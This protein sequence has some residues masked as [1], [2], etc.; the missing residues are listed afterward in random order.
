[1]ECAVGKISSLS[2]PKSNRVNW[3]TKFGT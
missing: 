2:D 1:M 3:W